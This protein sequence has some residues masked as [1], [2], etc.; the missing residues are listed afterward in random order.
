M[1]E[2]KT[3]IVKGENQ[4]EEL[5]PGKQTARKAGEAPKRE[6]T[7]RKEKRKRRAACNNTQSGKT[8]RWIGRK[9]A[10]ERKRELQKNCRL[11]RK[12]KERKGEP[13]SED[14]ILTYA[15]EIRNK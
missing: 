6:R 1:K 13:N 4:Q 7:S 12:T 3:K 14:R 11:G 8:E 2:P 5:D 15:E 10:G 9:N